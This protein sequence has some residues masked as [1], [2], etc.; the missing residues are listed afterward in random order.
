[1]QAACQ[2]DVGFFVLSCIVLLFTHCFYPAKISPS[3]AGGAVCI[4][5]GVLLGRS[6]DIH[7]CSWGCVSSEAVFCV[8]GWQAG[9]SWG[10]GEQAPACA[11]H[12]AGQ[13]QPGWVPVAALLF[14]RV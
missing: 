11:G 7:G 6:S 4:S 10:W 2:D 5:S 1:M 9:S 14:Q 12:W 13:P 8:Q 3:N